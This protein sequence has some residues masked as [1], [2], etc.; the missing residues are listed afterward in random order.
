MRIAVMGTGGV[1]G[2]YGGLLAKQGHDV[3]FI[4]RGAHLDA[5]REKGLQVKSIHGDFTVFPAR[6]S[7][8]P[9]GI[10]VVDLVIFC[11]KTYDTVEAARKIMSLV[12]PDTTVMS[13][14]NG[15]DAA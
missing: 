6:I 3:H 7:S 10:G 11:T 2:Y 8:N 13:L 4:A 9:A 14:Q 15:I 5:I 1:G 12:G